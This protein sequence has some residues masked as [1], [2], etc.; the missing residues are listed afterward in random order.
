MSSK[1]K[2]MRAKTA[3]KPDVVCPTD[4]QIDAAMAAFEIAKQRYK[5]VQRH[6]LFYI[7]VRSADMFGD[8]P[9]AGAELPTTSGS[10]DTE[11]AA[12]KFREREIIR[13][14]IIAGMRAK[15]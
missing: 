2:P 12:R 7:E 15:P 8:A 3:A 5:L 4:N 6:T 10:F 1:R 13:E 14:S 11:D 9:C